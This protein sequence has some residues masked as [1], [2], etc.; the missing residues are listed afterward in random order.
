MRRVLL[1]LGVLLVTSAASRAGMA[2]GDP[3]AMPHRDGLTG[4]LLVAEPTLDD[5]NFVHTVVLIV[6]HDDAG[7]L[8]LVVNRPYGTAPTKELLS[9]LGVEAGK[10]T[11]DTLLFYGGPVQPTVGMVVHSTDYAMAETRRVTADLAVTSN[12]TI[13]ADIAAGKGPKRY[14]P[15]LGYA[16]WAPDQLEQELAQG[17][18]AVIPAD[19][20]LIFAPDVAK[21][22]ERAIARKGTDL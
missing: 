19:P 20:E 18:W 16:G 5:P 4:Q 2:V 22:W 15:V 13:L 10:V 7:A 11:G 3:R 8:G 12:P 9:R 21:A 6:Q 14:V 17:A 1:L